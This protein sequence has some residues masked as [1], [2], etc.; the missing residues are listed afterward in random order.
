M[1]INK[2]EVAFIEPKGLHMSL[3]PTIMPYYKVVFKNGKALSISKE[4]GEKLIKEM[5]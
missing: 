4:Q 2:S 3:S 5:K 1:Y